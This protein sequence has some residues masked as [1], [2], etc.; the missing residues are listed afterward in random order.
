MK[1]LSLLLILG[2]TY[3]TGFSQAIRLQENF[4]A[5]SLPTGWTNTAVSGTQTWNFGING[6]ATNAGNNN[7]DGTAMAF[8]DDDNLGAGNTNSTVRLTSPTFDNSTDSTST[9]EFDYNFREF[10]G[11]TDR[12]YVEVYD[13]TAW[14]TVFSTTANDCGNWLG[15]CAGNFP[16]ANID[17]SAHKNANCQVRFTYHDGNDWCWYVGIDNVTV[18]SPFNNDL[19]VTE[20][21]Y[22]TSSCSLGTAEQAQ[23][24][25]KNTGSNNI[26]GP[27][28]VIINVNNGAQV[29]TETVTNSINV[30]DSILYT[31]SRFINLSNSGIY[32][33]KVYTR[34]SLDPNSLND[35]VKSNVESVAALT[36]PVTQDF[37]GIVTN[38]NSYGQNSSW[39]IGVPNATIFS[40]AYQGSA[41]LV[42]NLTGNY[43]NYEVSYIETPCFDDNQTNRVPIVSFY[44]NYNSEPNFDKLELEF[45][46]D[47]GATWQTI[48][49][50]TLSTNWYQGNSGWTGNSNG[51]IKVEN[52]L[53]S[54]A[55]RNSFKLRFKLSTDGSVVREGYAIDNFNI[56]LQEQVD[57]S[58][59]AIG[60]PSNSPLICGIGNEYINVELTNS[61]ILAIDSTYVNYQVNNG[62]IV[63]ELLDS[64]ITFGET[65]SYRFTTPFNFSA[66]GT[67]SIDAWISVRN[68][69]FTQND[70]VINY[71]IVN[72]NNTVSVKTFPYYENFDGPQ[73]IASPTNGIDSNWS[74]TPIPIAT[75][76]GIPNNYAWHVNTGATASTLTGP[77]SGYNSSGNYMYTEASGAFNSSSAF[78]TTPCVRIPINS[79]PRLQFY[80]HGY[81]NS[82]PDL[83]VE[84]NN[85][86]GWKQIANFNNH[87]QTSHTSPWSLR[88]IDLDA[89]KGSTIKLRFKTTHIGNFEGDLAIDE[90]DISNVLDVDLSVNSIT[91]GKGDCIASNSNTVAVLLENKGLNDILPNQFTLNYKLNNNAVVSELFNDT[92]KADSVTTFEFST[93]L[94]SSR[95]NFNNFI[96]I[97]STNILDSNKLNDTVSTVF[98]NAILTLP[99]SEN[100]DSVS[101]VVCQSGSSPFPVVLPNNPNMW[102]SN[103][104]AWTIQNDTAC[105]FTLGQGATVTFNTGPE[106]AASGNNFLFIDGTSTLSWNSLLSIGCFDFSNESN[107]TLE[108]NYH[109]YTLAT[110]PLGMG[111]LY[112]EVKNSA[113]LTTTVDSIIGITHTNAFDPWL[114]RTI[115]LSSFSGQTVSI[116]IRGVTLTS[117][118]LPWQGGDMAIDDVHIYN[119]LTTSVKTVPPQKVFNLYPNPNNGNFN[120]NVSNELVGKQYQVFDVKGGLVKQARIDAPNSQIELSNAE[121]G[122]YFIKIEGYAKAERIVVL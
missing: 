48:N 43:N 36:F 76:N 29:L 54:V 101:N 73:W 14:N 42:T 111:D 4:N 70:S 19:S 18:S 20:L 40:S 99:F 67:Y 112:I 95:P 46:N 96:T 116:G 74:F 69:Q 110:S 47:N 50:G 37:E 114:L 8:F 32:S 108:F 28:N 38:W 3:F 51:W 49:G 109:K 2:F 85:G 58:L 61:G 59:N 16:H 118:G 15:A 63:S 100:F 9:L 79:N 120:L 6:S 86:T 71:Q 52:Y 27:F 41:A 35:T 102:Q 57:L 87:P 34:S 65:I 44:L 89:Y 11:P 75:T 64:T 30:G 17:I 88:K 66:I 22:P 98:D 53:D 10:V 72:A 105:N 119:P 106:L 78:L 60:Y 117:A 7:L 107:I 56:R 1:K 93:L 23:V 21:V 92:L 33:I 31:F 55:Y 121:K 24:V 62:P 113:G 13:G 45:S 115:N 122:V 90:I 83:I 5:A 81:G 94:N 25:I 82:I 84:A 97:Y 68:D 91:I 77:S 104:P 103:T 80:T 26:S 12:F 39:Q